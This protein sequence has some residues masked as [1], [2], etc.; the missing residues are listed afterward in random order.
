MMK[1]RSATRSF[2]NI[3]TSGLKY[4]V[5]ARDVREMLQKQGGMCGAWYQAFQHMA[6]C[7][8]VFV[9]RRRFLVDWRRMADGEE[10]WCAIVIRSG[11]QI[12]R[13]QRTLLAASM[14][15]TRCSR[16]RLE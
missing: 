2:A 14:T 16:S 1:K 15:M 9:Y 6:H 7:Q 3:G 4:G 11:G 8:G 5:H 12:K 10:H 13:T